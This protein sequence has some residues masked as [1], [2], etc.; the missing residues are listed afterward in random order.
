MK[1]ILKACDFFQRTVI[2]PVSTAF[3]IVMAN[4]AIYAFTRTEVV[5]LTYV[6]VLAT[7]ICLAW[8][9]VFT[10]SLVISDMVRDFLDGTK[11]RK[12]G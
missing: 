10:I 6:A 7:G 1:T 12:R 4:F 8:L 2:Y 3:V 9:V 5:W 11:G